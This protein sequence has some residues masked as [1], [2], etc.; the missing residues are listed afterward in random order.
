MLG[1]KIK[2][3]SVSDLHLGSG[4]LQDFP[5]KA[6]DLF[7]EI[8]KNIK[9]TTQSEVYFVL[10]GDIFDFPQTPI[11]PE[12][13]LPEIPYSDARWGCSEEQS[14]RKFENIIRVHSKFFSTLRTMVEKGVKIVFLPGNHDPDMLWPSLKKRFA[15]E[16]GLPGKENNIFPL[17]T[18]FDFP[19]NE[20]IVH[21]EHGHQ[22]LEDGNNFKGYW[23][24]EYYEKQRKFTIL[25]LDS[26]NYGPFRKADPY[27]GEDKRLH[28]PYGTRMMYYIMN[29]LDLC[30]PGIDNIKPLTQL[31][32]ALIHFKFKNFLTAAYF[33]SKWSCIE[34][35]AGSEDKSGANLNM[36]INTAKRFHQE[37]YSEELEKGNLEKWKEWMSRDE[38]IKAG[39]EGSFRFYKDHVETTKL[40][41]YAENIFK[42][43][44]S[45]QVV[46]NGHTHEPDIKA[47]G[48]TFFINTGTW[49]PYLNFKKK[50]GDIE[51]F[52]KSK[53]KLK[54]PDKFPFSPKVAVVIL[55]RSEGFY[56]LCSG[57]NAPSLFDLRSQKSSFLQKINN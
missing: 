9:R 52:L 22:L 24:K 28:N 19:E 26:I 25:T 27:N 32:R 14:L 54:D 3:L 23:P 53:E 2:I 5:K 40:L 57:S 4:K 34:L 17:S 13:D 42:K 48:N 56:K 41:K 43:S 45:I 38:L 51:P 39:V 50:D 55:E 31:T 21:I 18:V 16:I 49:I 36:V 46:V 37:N 8:F 44:E 30:Y 15:K 1:K 33:A 20:P 47:N 35:S 12:K 7:E 10:N 6:E 11:D 29:P